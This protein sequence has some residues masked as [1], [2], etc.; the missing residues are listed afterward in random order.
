MLVLEGETTWAAAPQVY[1][2]RAVVGLRVSG[3]RC[4]GANGFLRMTPMQRNPTPTNDRFPAADLPPFRGQV[5]KHMVHQV[6]RRLRRPPRPARGAKPASLAITE[7]QQLVVPAILAAQAQE[8]VRQDTAFQEGA[9][10]V[11]DELRQPGA[12]GLFGLGDE[13][14]GMLLHQR[15]ESR[16][17]P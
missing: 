2:L 1:A 16:P 13:T 8:P 15:D 7:G 4:E 17:G 11:T 3:H 12:G 6:R 14:L 5:A 10:L 9:E